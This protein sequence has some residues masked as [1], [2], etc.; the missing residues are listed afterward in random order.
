MAHIA[1]IKEYLP[2]QHRI[3]FT[4]NANDGTNIT[5]RLLKVGYKNI[6][7][8]GGDGTLNEI[9]NGFFNNKAKNRSALDP[10]KF[11]PEQSLSPINQSNI[12]D[13]TFGQ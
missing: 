10:M 1:A 11:K 12:L 5:R 4:K 7:A 13:H 9:A 8:V 6:T 3:I 2:K